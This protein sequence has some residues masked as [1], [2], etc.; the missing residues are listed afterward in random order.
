MKR[1]QV[2]IIQRRRMPVRS[3]AI[4]TKG[5]MMAICMRRDGFTGRE[6]G[7]NDGAACKHWRVIEAKLAKL[8]NVI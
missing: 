1:E 4:P 5:E 7:D 6:I 8:V 2:K 3:T